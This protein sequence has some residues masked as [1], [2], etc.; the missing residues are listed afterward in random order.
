VSAPE[1]EL[2][3]AMARLSGPV[4]P[5]IARGLQIT[6]NLWR[7]VEKDWGL[8]TSR[9]V[10]ELLSGGSHTADASGLRT[11][12]KIIGFRRNGQFRYPGFQFDHHSRRVRP[13]VPALIALSNELGYDAEAV[14]LS[15]ASPSTYWTDDTPLNHIDDEDFLHILKARWTAEW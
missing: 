13:V 12:G 9:Q 2:A 6:E 4:A 10:V 15:L 7:Q 8:L 14:I 11:A 3:A 1:K 5:E